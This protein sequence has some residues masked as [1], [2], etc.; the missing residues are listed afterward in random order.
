LQCPYCGFRKSVAPSEERIREKSVDTALR[1]PRD[2]GWGAE[3]KVMACKRCGAHTTLDPHVSASACAFCG[4]TAVVEAPPNAAVVRPEGLLP[5]RITRES[6]LQSF[7]KWLHSL[8]LRPNDLKSASRINA[9]QGAYIPFWTFD[10]A[11]DSWWTAEAGYFYYVNV[12]VRENGRM[13]TQRQQRIRWEPASGALQLFFDDVP[14]PAS[15]GVDETLTRKLEPF[16]TADLTPY[17]PSYLSGFLAEEN[18]V[19]LPEAL[20]TAKERMRSD[21]R[22]ACARQVPGDTHRSLSVQTAFD[23]VAY[24]NALLPIWI[25]AYEYRSQPYRFLVNGVTG[26]CTGTAPWSWIKVTLLVL[27]IIT[28][29]MVLLVLFGDS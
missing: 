14:V 15:R 3:R 29:S 1:A 13:V 17:E 22:D 19:D 23:A 12:Q 16:P 8:W 20:E 27:T 4:T 24:K 9:M 7:R 10:A 5:F 25:A 18:A 11:T 6:A 2:V 28:I 26:Q 21:I